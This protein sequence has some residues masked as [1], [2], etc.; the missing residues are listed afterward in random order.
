MSV[1]VQLDHAG[2]NKINV[3]KVVRELTGFGLKEAKDLVDTAP[4]TLS[5]SLSPEEATRWQQKLTEAGA[6]VSVL[7]GPE[8]A[9]T[10]PAGPMASLYL[11]VT[12]PNKI[13]VIKSIRQLTGLGLKEAKD[14]AEA[15]PCEITKAAPLDEAEAV[16]RQLTADGAR[17][18][19]TRLDSPGE[20]PVTLRL[21]GYGAYKINVIKLIKDL[22]GLGL[23]ETKDLVE[24]TDQAPAVVGSF[25]RAEAERVIR[26]LRALGVTASIDEDGAAAAPRPPEAV[27]VLHAHGPNKINV[28]KIVRE[29]TGLGLKDAKD[30]VEA[31]AQGPVRLGAPQEKTRAEA[32]LYELRSAGA[33]AELQDEGATTAATASLWLEVAGHNKIAVI[34]E[35]RALTGLGLKE[36]KDLVE[37]VPSCILREQP[38][39]N[40]EAGRRAIEAQ[41]GR[42]SIRGEV[43]VLPG[44]LPEGLY[45]L[46]LA[47]AGERKIQ[48]IK[49]V[50]E[51]T[52]LG[53]KEALDLVESAPTLLSRG[54]AR[55]EALRLQQDFQEDGA[56]VELR[57]S[58][59]PVA[60][61]APSPAKSAPETVQVETLHARASR[62]DL[63]D[64]EIWVLA[65][66]KLPAV[67]H[68]LIE[69][70]TLS[71]G[72]LGRLAEASDVGR[73]S[74][75]A[76]HPNTPGYLLHTLVSDSAREVRAAVA[77]REDAPSSALSSLFHDPEEAV[78]AAVAGNPGLSSWDLEQLAA[79][80]S[81]V[82]K[83][84]VARHP[85]TPREVI[86][87]LAQQGGTLVRDALLENSSAPLALR[88]ALAL[89]GA[90]ASLLGGKEAP[91]LSPGDELRAWL[92][93]TPELTEAQ[94]AR[95]AAWTTN[96]TG[97]G[98]QAILL[99]LAQHPRSP[100]PFL[101]ALTKH[102]T[103]IAEQVA[104]NPS[105]PDALREALLAHPT[106]EIAQE[107][108]AHLENPAPKLRGQARAEV[109]I[110]L[111]RNPRCPESALRE[112][113]QANEPWKR[114]A[115]A[116]NPSA[117]YDLLGQLAAE[118]HHR[119]SLGLARNP[120][121][122]SSLLAQLAQHEEAEIRR[123]VAHNPS[124]PYY[125]LEEL[126]RDADP[127]VRAAAFHNP[128]LSESFLANAEG[129]E[130]KAAQQRRAALRS[131]S[132][133]VSE[134]PGWLARLGA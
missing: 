16:L 88:A 26:E 96:Y 129:A 106:G 52:R 71:G 98:K 97:P 36:A 59:A 119:V 33:S 134:I 30:L 68:S 100:V 78:R 57:P 21:S 75:A 22:T 39:E 80:P 24:S 110:G 126:A 112:A 60:S 69:N 67:R 116:Q 74:L 11:N 5:S 113:A 29:L 111:L 115:A 64:D 72:I 122:S 53:L 62:A 93:S 118:N 73:R 99:A 105:T 6:R 83:A 48:V 108:A 107:A 91:A 44:P 46:F 81:A 101:D 55:D 10:S 8:V 86:E 102:G 40:L 17:A 121:A 31:T 45:D 42:A 89:L 47:R 109:M 37:N 20:A 27:L 92:A 2:A 7:G 79:D 19:L 50:R 77:H 104:K 132:W 120:S 133:C 12:G 38:R 58:A 49:R 84:A 4:S 94:V 34:K 14:L 43:Q 70:S 23:K 103:P 1:S 54:L 65:G 66:M 41:G 117:S 15:A 56:S 130:A 95:L 85:S 76:S 87:A 9:P 131:L 35:I 128:S 28:I 63:S 123:A 13:A 127:Q 25:P 124:A 82:V 32:A 18:T 90:G 61:A 51:L 3:I 114:A 125:T